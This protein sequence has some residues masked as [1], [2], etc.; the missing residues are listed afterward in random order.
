MNII[1]PPDTKENT[2]SEHDTRI[3]ERVN[4]WAKARLSDPELPMADRLAIYGDVD[5]YEAN[6]R[7]ASLT[8]G[9]QWRAP[10]YAWE[11]RI[12]GPSGC[13]ACAGSKCPLGTSNWRLCP[14]AK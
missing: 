12:T 10:R 2:M 7:D 9:G 13:P 8:R 4:E 14:N 3:K 5:E 11:D 1:T 6:S